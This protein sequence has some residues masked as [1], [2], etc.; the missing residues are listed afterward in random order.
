VRLSI[1]GEWESPENLGTADQDR[2]EEHVKTLASRL[3]EASQVAGQQSKLSHQIA[4]QY[5]DS[6]T[7]FENFK[8]GDLVYL[9]DPTHKRGKVTKSAYQFKG[10]Y[11]IEFKL[12]PLVYRLCTGEG[13][14]IIVH[15]NRLKL[16]HVR[17]PKA[18]TFEVVLIFQIII[19][20]VE[21]RNI[22]EMNRQNE[23]RRKEIPTGI[24]TRT[25]V[26][27]ENSNDSNELQI[28]DN[29]CLIM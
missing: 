15:I 7:K 11:E 18:S 23:D 25:L 24:S 1:K 21:N 4:K 12:S 3:H 13:M 6:H 9:H 10:P 26:D 17:E 27:N 14:F 19:D 28:E 2:Y 29:M 16:T 22:I 5:Y 8:R 20:Y